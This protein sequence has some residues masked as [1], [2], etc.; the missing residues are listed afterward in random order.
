MN[1]IEMKEKL[2]SLLKD[3]D[4]TPKY[5][6]DVMGKKIDVPVKYSDASAFMVFFSVSLE[7]VKNLLKSNRLVPV[8]ITPNKCLMGITFF[9]YRA[10]PVGPYHEFTFSIPVLVDSGF[11]IPFLPIIFDSFFKNF[12]Y[13]VILMGTDSD[14]SRAHIE[15][16]FSYPMVNKNLY[17]NLEERDNLLSANIKDAGVE[18]ISMTHDSPR[19]YKLEKKRYNTYYKK[20]GRIYNVKLQTFSFCTKIFG[21]TQNSCVHIGSHQISKMLKELGVNPEP[22]ASVY[23]KRA[24]EVAEGPVDV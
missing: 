17:I 16:I 20:D 5:Q 19:S 18:V 10:C 2:E 22:L 24:I 4:Y 11:H 9:D 3:F 6:I 12:G 15:K 23:Y 13:N 8:I 21:K 7:K 14:I 1:E